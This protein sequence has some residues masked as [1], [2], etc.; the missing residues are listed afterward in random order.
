MF[1]RRRLLAET[2]MDLENRGVKSDRGYNRALAGM[3][4]LIQEVNV[5]NEE[6]EA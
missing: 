3:R 6:E 2:A 1:C 5:I 4:E